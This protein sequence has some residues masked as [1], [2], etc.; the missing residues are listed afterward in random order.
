M[1]PWALLLPRRRLTPAPAIPILPVRRERFAH[2]R[3]RSPDPAPAEVTIEAGW[4]AVKSSAALVTA[5][6]EIPQIFATASGVHG[7]TAA[8]HFSKLLVFCAMKSLFSLPALMIAAAIPLRKATSVPGLIAIWRS[9]IFA[10]ALVRASATMT[11]APFFWAMMTRRPA[12][13]FSSSGLLPTTRIAFALEMSVIELV[14]APWP[15]A[16]TRPL[17][18][19]ALQRRPQ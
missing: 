5:S 13:G 4:A 12:S 7:A 17:T 6:A 10:V 14:M 9:A 19:S 11:F 18:A 3:I 16:S 8:L 2:A 1:A 15:K